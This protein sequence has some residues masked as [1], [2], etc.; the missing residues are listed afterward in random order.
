M[1]ELQFE[2]KGDCDKESVVVLCY[3]V[4][5]ENLEGKERNTTV[6]SI[7]STIQKREMEKKEKKIESLEKTNADLTSEHIT[8]FEKGL[9]VAKSRLEPLKNAVI[10]QR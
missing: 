10:E 1:E 6:Q 8:F 4:V 5:L 7:L 2:E 3:D 9:S